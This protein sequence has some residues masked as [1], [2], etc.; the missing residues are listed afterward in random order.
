MSV[1][2][3]NQR[4]GFAVLLGAGLLLGA[5]LPARAQSVAF[6][7]PERDCC[8]PPPCAAVVIPPVP[9]EIPPD[10]AAPSPLDF[11]APDERFAG[12]GSVAYAAPM[13]GDLLVPSGGFR[14]VVFG[15]N[16]STPTAQSFRLPSASHG[17]KIADNGSPVPQDRVFLTYNYFNNVNGDFNAAT[18]SPIGRV[19]AHQ[20]VFGVEKTFFNQNASVEFRLPLNTLD[21]MGG[22]VPGLGGTSTDLGDLTVVFK[23]VLLQNRDTGNL[24]SGGLAITMPTGPSNFAGVAPIGPSLG[25]TPG[26]IGAPLTTVAHDTLLQ[27]WLGYLFTQGDFYVHGFSSMDIPTQSNDVTLM[28]N[29]IGVGYYLFRDRSSDRTLTAVIPTV[30]LHVNTPLNHR[31]SMNG[32]LGTPDWVDFTGGATFEFFRRSTLAIGASAP[33]TGAK[34]YDVEAIVQLNVRF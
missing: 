25:T 15:P 28:F 5:V 18:M 26:I 17:F 22:S 24:L 32:P 2:R 14:T 27:P 30:E 29:D 4:K 10:G 31:G 23:G 13:I 3:R 16:G 12:R 11:Q 21:A 33:V 19:D 8:A 20:T 7:R 9:G 1:L 34:P 6:G